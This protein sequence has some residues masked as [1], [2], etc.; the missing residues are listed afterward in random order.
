[1]LLDKTESL[2]NNFAL[3]NSKMTMLNQAISCAK[4]YEENDCFVVC[5]HS[6]SRDIYIGESATM[7][8]QN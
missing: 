7:H 6:E 2:D 1:M 3:K 5:L 4:K 8:A